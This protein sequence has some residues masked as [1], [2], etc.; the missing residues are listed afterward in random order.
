MLEKMEKYFNQR[1]DGKTH[2]TRK[3]SRGEIVK[4]MCMMAAAALR[5]G[6][7]LRELWKRVKGPKDIFEPA[8]TFGKYG[9]GINR[10]ELLE[11]LTGQCYALEAVGM[12]QSDPWR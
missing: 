10:F 1:L 12:D 5:P 7:P 2:A 6:I 3:T 9:I 11:K 8:A 4:L